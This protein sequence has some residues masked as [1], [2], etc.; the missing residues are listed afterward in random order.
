MDQ[1]MR[2]IS[3]VV[4]RTGAISSPFRL[5]AANALQRRGQPM[6]LRV[7]STDDTKA[8]ENEPE[9]RVINNKP[10]ETSDKSSQ[11][12]ETESVEKQL[13]TQEKQLAELKV[14]KNDNLTC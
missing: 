9:K 12:K 2:L 3:R 8:V 10:E 13:A 7:Y 1:Y 5:A 4:S 14:N 6:L 11:T